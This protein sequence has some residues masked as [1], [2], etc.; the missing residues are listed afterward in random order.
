MNITKNVADSNCTEGVSLP[1]RV[2]CTH[3]NVNNIC[4]QCT[5]SGSDTPSAVQ[6]SNIIMAGRSNASLARSI[7][8]KLKI[9]LANTHI[10][11]F[12]N[13][14]IRCEIQTNIRKKDV[15]IVQTG[16]QDQIHSINDYIFELFSL[17]NACKLSGARSISAIIPYYPYSRSDKKDAPRAPI[18]AALFAN[19]LKT[20]GVTRIV[21]MDLHAGQIQGFTDISFD[22]LYSRNLIIKKMQDIYFHQLSNDEINEKYILISPDHGG[23][24]RIE[25]Y[26]FQLK[27]SYGIM[28]KQRDYTKSSCVLNSMYIGDTDKLK[29]KMAIII[30]DMAD[31]FGTMVSSSNELSKY[32]V[33]GIIIVVTHGILSGTAISKMN[34]CDIIKNVIVTNTLD[35]SENLTKT[36]KLIVIDTSELFAEVIK[37]IQTGGSISELF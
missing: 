17:T 4:V 26:A 23:V 16:A 37:R 7:S 27:M 11:D 5:L 32:G 3:K 9:P 35:Q 18:N 28:H 29:G 20:C 19:L 6:D 13:S 36:N 30:D 33:K 1:I 10:S 15:Y 24:K 34:D 22:N 12:S 31:T 25:A 14:E 2:H 21:S 8:E